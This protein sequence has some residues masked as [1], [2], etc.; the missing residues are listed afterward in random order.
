MVFIEGRTPKAMLATTAVLLATVAVVLALSKAP[1]LNPV[2]KLM[3][4]L[5]AAT[6][7]SA[8]AV[9]VLVATNPAATILAT[10]AVLLATVAVVFALSKAPWLKPVKNDILALAVL[11]PPCIIPI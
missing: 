6:P 2:K 7:A 10:T 3:L 11:R 8:I 5:A 1:W 9:L 4:L